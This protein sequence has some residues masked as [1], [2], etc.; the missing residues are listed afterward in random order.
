MRIILAMIKDQTCAPGR[1]FVVHRHPLEQ[2]GQQVRQ[3][4]EQRL[5]QR[6]RQGQPQGYQGRPVVRERGLLQ[7]P[8]GGRVSPI[9]KEK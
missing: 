8:Q 3:A 6:R 4:Q 5:V 9:Y 1:D 2:V 7:R